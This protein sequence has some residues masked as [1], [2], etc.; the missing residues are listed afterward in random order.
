M[1]RQRKESGKTRKKW[2]EEG[3]CIEEKTRNSRKMKELKPIKE[4][5]ENKRRKEKG[6]RKGTNRKL[7]EKN[8]E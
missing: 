3:N 2:K 6:T 7:R 8:E 4:R 5:E 1:S